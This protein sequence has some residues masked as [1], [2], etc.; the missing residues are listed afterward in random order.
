MAASPT[1]PHCW[2]LPRTT[3][4]L[5]FKRRDEILKILKARTAAACEHFGVKPEYVHQKAPREEH[6]HILRQS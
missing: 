6:V 5:T 4:K 1:V 3:A 2:T